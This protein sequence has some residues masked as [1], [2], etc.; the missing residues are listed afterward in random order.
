MKQ[1]LHKFTSWTL[2]F[3]DKCFWAKKNTKGGNCWS[4][5]ELCYLLRWKK[6]T[7]QNESSLNQKADLFC[8]GHDS[9]DSPNTHPKFC[10]RKPLEQDGLLS[11]LE[12]VDTFL[13][14]L[15]LCHSK[16]PSLLFKVEIVSTETVSNLFWSSQWQ[17]Y[18]DMLPRDL[19]A[20]AQPSW[21]AFHWGVS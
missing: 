11:Q 6:H 18:Q 13:L 12:V 15:N 4:L 1:F 8:G 21:C 9:P 10:C 3:T 14:L 16:H 19:G 2:T 17:S 20:E 5:P 7:W